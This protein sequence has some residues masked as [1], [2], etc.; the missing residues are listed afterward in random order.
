MGGEG[1]SVDKHNKSSYHQYCSL[2]VHVVHV[3]VGEGSGCRV[4]AWYCVEV[5]VVGVEAWIVLRVRM[6]WLSSEV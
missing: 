3:H 1:K 2:N 5:W 4:G 6:L